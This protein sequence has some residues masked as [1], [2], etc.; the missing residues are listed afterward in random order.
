MKDSIKNGDLSLKYFLTGEMYGYLFTKPL[1][2]ATFRRFHAMIQRIPYS[3]PD[4]DTICPRAIVKVTSRV[5]WTEKQTDTSN[6]HR[7]HGFSWGHVYRCSGKPVHE[8]IDTRKYKQG[9]SRKHVHRRYR[10]CVHRHHMHRRSC[11]SMHGSL[12][13]HIILCERMYGRLC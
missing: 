12:C 1:Q 3:T 6:S 5:C 4:V 9:C 11:E 2:G 7:N 8:H 13:V 10:N